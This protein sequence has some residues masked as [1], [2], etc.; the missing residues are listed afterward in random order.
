L[1]WSLAS[2][3]RMVWEQL[4]PRDKKMLR[5]ALDALAARSD[6]G[7]DPDVETLRVGQQFV[8]VLR[9]PKGYRVFFEREQDQILVLDIASQA[10]IDFLR[11]PRDNAAA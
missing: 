2:T 10:Q 5:S 8:K 7:G 11:P 4:R 1:T 9:A 6:S 3:A